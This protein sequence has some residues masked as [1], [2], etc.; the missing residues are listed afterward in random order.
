MDGLNNDFFEPFV[1]SCDFNDEFIIEKLDLIL[2]S[3]Q[4]NT[5]IFISLIC[6]IFFGYIFARGITE[7]LGRL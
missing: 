3:I 1:N 6:G 2:L 7:N 5:G 4:D